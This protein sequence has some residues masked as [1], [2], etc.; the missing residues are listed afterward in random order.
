[1]LRRTLSSTSPLPEEEE[2]ESLYCSEN[3]LSLAENRAAI[4]YPSARL[5]S[6]RNSPVAR[7]G[8]VMQ[9]LV[10]TLSDESDKDTREKNEHVCLKKCDEDFENHDRERHQEWQRR[11]HIASEREDESDER[12]HD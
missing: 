10:C 2:R 11:E 3:S 7:P 4:R 9:P 8:T 6:Q 1:M 12:E 5:A